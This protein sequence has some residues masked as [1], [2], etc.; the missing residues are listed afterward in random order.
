[1]IDEELRKEST[2]TIQWKCTSVLDRPIFING[3][4]AGAKSR[5]KRIID[6]EKENVKLKKLSLKQKK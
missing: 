3:Y 5:E 4:I 2:Y 6:L 1:M